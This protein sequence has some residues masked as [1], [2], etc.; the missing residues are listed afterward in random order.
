L[1]GGFPGSGELDADLWG[2]GGEIAIEAADGVESN[3]DLLIYLQQV[4][5]AQN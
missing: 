2:Q 1:G 4:I 5:L 3:K